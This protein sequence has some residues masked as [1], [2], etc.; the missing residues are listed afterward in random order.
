[1]LKKNAMLFQIKFLAFIMIIF[2][3][4]DSIVSNNFCDIIL[5]FF[6]QTNFMINIIFK[7]K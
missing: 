7:K 3:V 4:R 5:L 6:S 2:F 1:M